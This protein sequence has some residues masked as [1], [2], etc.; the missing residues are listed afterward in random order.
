MLAPINSKLILFVACAGI[1]ITS[2][3]MQKRAVD[4]WNQSTGHAPL[5]PRGRG[6]WA[7]YV[8]KNKLDTPELFRVI[9]IWG[10]VGRSAVIVL[11]LGIIFDT[12]ILPHLGQ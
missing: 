11:W 7:T 8:R 3:F 9:S 2:R 10:W 5:I 1:F 4:K 6:I 12:C